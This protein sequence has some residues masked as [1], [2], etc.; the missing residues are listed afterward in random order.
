MDESCAVAG[1]VLAA[2]AGRR[3][4]GPKALARD[5]ASGPT[6]VERAVC[7]LAASGVSPVLVV[8]GAEGEAVA[9]VLDT[10]AAP[11]DV[12]L[13][14]V[15]APDWR[16]GMG[17]SLRAGLAAAAEHAPQADGVLVTLVDL[18]DV[19]ETVHRRVLAAG[20]PGGSA[21]VSADGGDPATALVRAAYDGRPGHPVLLGRT[22]W[23]AVAAGARGDRGAREFFATHPHRL[24]E[25]GDL[26]SG[27]DQDR[28]G[29]P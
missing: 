2:G 13:V 16:E 28:F 15:P 4:G 17:A 11:D 5:S 21:A 6:W 10:M 3:F 24:V 25:C 20:S 23:E 27:R 29:D 14:V 7:R 22:H 19:D 9:E 18:P 12:E 1:L 8:V 26:A